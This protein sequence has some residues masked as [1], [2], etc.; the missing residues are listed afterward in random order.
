[1]PT[2][3]PVDPAT[4]TGKA[5]ELLAQVRKTL[6]R[7]PNM[8]KVMAN[9][10]ALLQGYLSLSGALGAGVLPAGVREQLAI[11]T[12]AEIGEVVGHLALNVLTNY[13]NVLADVE[14]DWPVVSPA[15][16]RPPDE[17]RRGPVMAAN[18]QPRG[19]DST[20]ASSPCRRQAGVA[21]QAARLAGCSPRGELRG[22]FARFLADRTFAALTARDADGRLWISPLAGPPGFLDATGPDHL[23]VHAVPAR[24]TRCTT[25]RRGS[26]SG[27]SSS[28]SPPDG[29]VRVNGTLTAAAD[30]R[31]EHRGRTGLRQLPAVHPAAR[32]HTRP[33]TPASARRP[34]QRAGLV[35]E[36]RELI[37]RA[38]TFF[39]GTTH[40]NRGADASHRG[41]PPGF[42]T[43]RRRPALVARLP[44]QQHVQHSRQPRRRPER[45][46]A[47]SRLRHRPQPSSCPAPRRSTGPRLARPATT[48]RPD[49]WSASAPSRSSPR[50]CSSCSRHR[51]LR[52]RTPTHRRPL[53]DAPRH[54][55]K[56]R[57]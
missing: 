37:R 35:A 48:T 29:R 19:W 43:R 54:Q 11:A 10:P 38:D 33:G 28:S 6:G 52:R 9:S 16:A 2:I 47:R 53:T 46:A 36:D 34:P 55:L 12:D 41:G 50:T 3:A 20:R 7:T 4:A 40:P 31:V 27:W 8:T 15:R 13:F 30:G 44:R 39:I 57:P 42:V 1:M 21:A 56:G 18:G 14:N 32:A 51:A 25:C 23:T 49:A 45:R 22:G 17:Q 5:A 26:R 24:A